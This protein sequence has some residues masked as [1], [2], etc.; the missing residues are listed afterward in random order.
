MKSFFADAVATHNIDLTSYDFLIYIIYVP[1]VTNDPHFDRS[2]AASTDSYISFPLYHSS[3]VQNEGFLTVV[4][5]M[6][7]KTFQ[8][9]DLYNGFARQYP[10]GVPDPQR[11]PQGIACIMGKKFGSEIRSGNPAIALTYSTETWESSFADRGLDRFYTSDP[12]NLGLCVDLIIRILDNNPN[13]NCS[14]AE[15][16][17]NECGTCIAKNYLT[18]AKL[19][20]ISGRARGPGAV[21]IS[22]ISVDAAAHGT[23]TTDVNGDYSFSEVPKGT[24]VGVWRTAAIAI[25]HPELF[26]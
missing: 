6:G 12:A 11:F 21:G 19:L 4:H 10:L 17:S 7:H 8:A 24:K 14:L 23:T 20:T 16:N 2:F 18:C 3:I 22:G 1:E 25:F 26:A 9:A 15:F 5:E 13:P